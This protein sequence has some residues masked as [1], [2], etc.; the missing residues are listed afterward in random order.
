[1]SIFVTGA[2]GYLG[3]RLAKK[4]IS[5]GEKVNLLARNP[6]ALGDMKSPN[7]R[8]FRGD[9][10]D[11]D[12]VH[13]AME[14]C[15]QVLHV[16]ALA[17]LWTKD[18]NDFYRI[19]VD[20]TKMVLQAAKARNIEKFVHTSTGGVSGPSLSIP[21]TEETPRWASFNNDYEI[22]K[23]LA[24]EEV[25]KAF[26]EG[27]PSVIVR[28]TR[29]FGPGIASPSAG[30]NRLISGYMKKRI[31][32]MPYDPK[33]VCNYGFIDDIV[34]GHI[35]AMRVGKPGEKYFLGGENVSYESL[36]DL[37]RKNVNQ[38]GLVLRAPK[39]AINTLSWI[40]FLL[41]RSFER[42]PSITPDFVVR[43]GQNA[44]CDCSKAVGQIGYK[45]TP[46]EDA[47]K[48]TIVSLINN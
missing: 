48:T 32:F 10:L 28:P 23:Y 11:Y 37:M 40:E 34:D 35:Q 5:I 6:D 15:Q 22:S 30:I 29:V 21:N 17:R 4:L 2:T 7:V 43:L 46:F 45:I 47:L 38:I 20:G 3:N 33:K 24:E 27:L 31:V 13:A 26:R 18:P 41:A 12:S 44:A 14:G 19:N 36:F 8:I 1:M 9:M 25:L 39:T 16:A 42:E